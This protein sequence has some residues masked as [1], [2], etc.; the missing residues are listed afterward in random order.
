MDCCAKGSRVEIHS[1]FW[2]DSVSW[3][4]H[5]TDQALHYYEGFF[6]F[7]KLLNASWLHALQNEKHTSADEAFYNYETS[8]RLLT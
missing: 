8:P 6:P 4:A 5:S 2:G 3:I 7:K 1:A